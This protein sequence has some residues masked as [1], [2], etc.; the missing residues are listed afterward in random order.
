MT[1]IFSFITLPNT[2]INGNDV[3]FASRESALEA[4]GDDFK[5]EVKGRDDRNFVL[6]SKDIGYDAKIPQNASIDQNPFAWPIYLVNGK[7]D[8]L[9]FDYNIK[10]DEGKLDE[11]LKE[12]PLFTNVTEP[13]DASLVF[14]DG[15][16]DVKDAVMGNKLE[17][18]KVKDQIVKAINSDHEDIELTDED[19]KNPEVLSDS[20]ELN[21][22]K[23]DAK[24][25]EAMNIKFNFNGFDIGLKGDK[26]VEMLV[27][28]GK[29]FELD[30]DKLLAFMKDVAD[31]TDT[32]G[33][34]RKFNATG[35][36]EITVN[37]GVYGYVLDQTATADEVLKLFNER[38]SGEVEPVYE[39]YGYERTANGTDIG[40]TYIEV[41]ISRQY[42]WFYKNGEL[43]IESPLVTGLVSPGWETNVGVG[44]ILSKSTNAKLEGV[45]FT[46]E[47]YKT[48]VDYWM[49]IGWDGEGFHDAPWRGGAFGGGIYFS[50]GSHGCLNLPPYVAQVI[51]ENAE[52]HTPVI[53]Y[54]SSTNNSPAM[55]Y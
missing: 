43:V 49:P 14:H 33:T 21:D 45:D 38:K 30:Y 5:L 15:S 42:L 29:V 46:G 48:P 55:A 44:S 6:N 32:Y 27:Q 12:S 1:V 40:N 3:S 9:K 41:D 34:E 37:P 7:K 54:E 19:Y 50:N 18:A 35:V 16:F 13:E 2:Y 8:D 11:L 53:V 22:L 23:E 10:Y 39:R 26:L 28:K 25:I 24:K 47:S 20:K 17:Y 52:I 51:Y 31:K 36:G 4:V